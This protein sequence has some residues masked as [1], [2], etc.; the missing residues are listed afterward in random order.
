M[1][2]TRWAMA[3]ALLLGLAVWLRGSAVGEGG[4]R[5]SPGLAGKPSGWMSRLVTRRGEPPIAPFLAALA[6]ELRAGQPTRCALDLACAG[7]APPPCP[8][9]RQAAI[10]GGDVATALRCD[11]RETGVSVLRSLA[12]CWEVAEHSGSGLAEAVDR[13]AQGHRSAQRAAGQLS[14]EVAA[15]RA[16]ARILALLPVFGLL[17][18]HWIGADP[19]GWLLGTWPGRAALVVGGLLQ[20]LGLM[21]LNRLT[22]GVRARLGP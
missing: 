19:L 1:A 18:G 6:A 14:A 11:A 10:V 5:A 3:A 21:W 4:G 2:S 7:L 17:V 13:L 22:A 9:A 12:A 16:S 15:A 20:L 8:T